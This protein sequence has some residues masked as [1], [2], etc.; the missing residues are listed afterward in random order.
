MVGNVDPMSVERA[1]L[2]RFCV[3]STALEEVG[4]VGGVRAIGAYL[5]AKVF[6]SLVW[7][8]LRDGNGL[9]CIAVGDGDW[10]R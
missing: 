6:V 4:F 5:D 10:N 1:K 7:S 9:I 3:T 8:K 2:H